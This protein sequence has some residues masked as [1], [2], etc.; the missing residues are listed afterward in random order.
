MKKIKRHNKLVRDNILDILK[1]KGIN[2]KFHVANNNE[3]ENELYLKLQ[4]E[5]EEFILKPCTEELVDM[6]EVLDAI[7]KFHNINLDELKIV[8]KEKKIERGGFNDRIILETT[9]E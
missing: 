4:E 6:L 2:C 8:K 1:D 7:R 9:K 3:Y 5:L